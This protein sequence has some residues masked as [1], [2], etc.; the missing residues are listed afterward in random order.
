M[1]I[2]EFHVDSA[3]G[4]EQVL[5]KQRFTF[6]GHQLAA[7]VRDNPRR[8]AKELRRLG[9][10]VNWTHEDEEPTCRWDRLTDY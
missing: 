1:A 10:A 4:W 2:R 3:P 9:Y 8:A 7:A 6:R 5:R